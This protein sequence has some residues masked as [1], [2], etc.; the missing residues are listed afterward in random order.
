MAVKH[1]SKS[2]AILQK[3]K[4]VLPPDFDPATYLPANPRVLIPSLTM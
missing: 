2:I 1:S 4:P 3:A